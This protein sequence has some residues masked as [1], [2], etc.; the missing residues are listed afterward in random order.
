MLLGASLLTVSAHETPVTNDD[1]GVELS[2]NQIDDKVGITIGTVLT[3]NVLVIR[4]G[5][6][7]VP[8]EAILSSGRTTGYPAQALCDGDDIGSSLTKTVKY[9]VTS[10]DLPPGTDRTIA[11]IQFR[12]AFVPEHVDGSTA[13]SAVTIRSN[14]SSVAVAR[15][16]ETAADDTSGIILSVGMDAPSKIVK[17]RQVTFTLRVATPKYGL[18]SGRTL[19]INKELYD[20]DGEEIG[21]ASPAVRFHIRAIPARSTSTLQTQKY[22]LKQ[23][24]VDAASIKFTYE[25]VVEF[26]HLRAADGGNPDLPT[27]FEEEFTDDGAFVIGALATPTPTATPVPRPVLIGST[28]SATITDRGSQVYIDRRGLGRDLTLTLGWIAANGDRD[29]HPLGFIRQAVGDGS[30]GQTYAVVRREFGNRG[31]VRIWVSPESP[32]RDRIVWSRVN[33]FYTVPVDVLREIPLDS[34][35]PAENQLVRRFDPGGDGRIYVFRNG[36]WRW[37]PDIPTFEAE[38]FFWCDV[39]AAD[40]GFFRRATIGSALPASGT[41]AD[42]NYPNCHNK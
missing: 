34:M 41:A 6:H 13:H 22:T 7:N 27:N 12:L 39:T 26:Q 23:E 31:V 19:R 10:G 3:Y 37:I 18:R 40:S 42:P 38:G 25:L 8:C 28:N 36:A 17:G 2:I 14:V 1:Y 4:G 15:K 16:V 24:D 20:A 35:H 29:Y 11:P 5:E 9:T 30:G 21:N 33:S 32:Q